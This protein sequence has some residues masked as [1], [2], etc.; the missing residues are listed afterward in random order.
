[1]GLYQCLKLTHCGLVT[2]YGDFEVGHNWF[3]IGAIRYQ[4][5]TWANVGIINKV[6]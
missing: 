6:Q 1:M 2:P 5:I 4:A 3:I